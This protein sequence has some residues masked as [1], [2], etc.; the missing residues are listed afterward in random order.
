MLADADLGHRAP[1]RL[2]GEAAAPEPA[3][4]GPAGMKDASGRDG[5]DADA[6]RG[7]LARLLVGEA[8][9]SGFRSVVAHR[10]AAFAAPDAR[11]M[12]DDA[13]VARRR[14]VDVLGR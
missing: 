12:D 5:E 7:K 10:A 2:L 4:R 3:L 1:T 13:R 9:E 8:D 6:P 11:H 14:A